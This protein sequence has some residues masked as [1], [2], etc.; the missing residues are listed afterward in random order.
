[1]IR[2]TLAAEPSPGE[3]TAGAFSSWLAEQLRSM[4]MTRRSLARRSGLNPSTI[5]RLLRDERR[6][7]I[8]T[9][10]RIVAAL[11]SPNAYRGPDRRIDIVGRVRHE[12]CADP[13]LRPRDVDRVMAR[14]LV[15]REGTSTQTGRPR[16][17]RPDRRASVPVADQPASR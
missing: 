16:G 15:Q 5:S 4:G 9:A 7:T 17:R 6:P 12:L 10:E 8:E 13:T 11:G 14:Y 2:R 1:M 3:S